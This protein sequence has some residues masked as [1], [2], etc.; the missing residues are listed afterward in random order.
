[1]ANSGPTTTSKK[2]IPEWFSPDYPP[3][4][5]TDNVGKA[6]VEG[7]LYYYPKVVRGNVDPAITN[8]VYANFSFLLFKEP[9]IAKNGKPVFGFI[10]SRGNWS[11]EK[12]ARSSGRK[13]IREVDSKH[14]VRVGLVGNW[15]P[16]TDENAV[17]KDLEDVRM[18]DSEIHLRDKAQKEKDSEQRKIMREI[19]E[20]EEELK[21]GGD[22][23]DDK[24]ALKY[25]SMKR[26]TE[27]SLK[28]ARNNMIKQLDDIKR[29]LIIV[30]NE[31]K[32][33]D[34]K[35]PSYED[36]WQECY[37]DERRKIKIPDM[38]YG[39]HDFDEYKNHKITKEKENKNEKYDTIPLH[40]IPASASVQL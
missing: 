32:S 20:R 35:Y 3:L 11:T 25:Y 16:I 17:C 19:R 37:N 7:Q 33:I 29:N 12:M 4:K 15:V 9:R 34:S 28:E 6:A 24:E 10:K 31:L 40:K 23:Y 21:N 18:N 14:Q 36:D 22:I 27:F 38:I 5:S 30:R 39:E 8:Q 2:E 1:M 13:I 26:V